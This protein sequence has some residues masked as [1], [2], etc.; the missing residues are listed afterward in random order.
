MRDLYQYDYDPH[1]YEHL[2]AENSETRVSVR[3]RWGW[4]LARTWKRR[5]GKLRLSSVSLRRARHV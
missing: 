4:V 2:V 1:K 5:S 3:W